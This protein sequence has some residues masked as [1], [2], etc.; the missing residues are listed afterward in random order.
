M[1]T[2]NVVLTDSQAQFVEQ[3]VQTGRYQNASEVMREGLRLVQ[4][5]EAEQA[6]KL[7]ALR[8]AVAVGIADIEAG[9]YTEFADT[10]SLR[11]HITA[12][13]KRVLDKHG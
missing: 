11:T 12:I 10:A 3:M 1:P 9:R 4:T 13:S 8:E 7:A 2:R 5:R 6:A